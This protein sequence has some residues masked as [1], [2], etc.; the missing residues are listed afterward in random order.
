MVI[1]RRFIFALLDVHEDPLILPLLNSCSKFG[2]KGICSL[3]VAGYDGLHGQGVAVERVR[4]ILHAPQTCFYYYPYYPYRWCHRYILRLESENWFNLVK[5]RG[6]NVE[7]DVVRDLPCA[8]ESKSEVSVI[9]EN[10][11]G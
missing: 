6:L 8:D 7:S 11:V 4:A 1:P 9:P 5:Y 3:L 2:D 10:V